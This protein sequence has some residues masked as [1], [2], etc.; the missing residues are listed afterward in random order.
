MYLARPTEDLG[1]DS[2]LVCHVVQM[3]IHSSARFIV[4][5]YISVVAHTPFF[6]FRLVQV[7]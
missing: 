2:I 1:I 5:F 3:G 6:L 7:V 4:I